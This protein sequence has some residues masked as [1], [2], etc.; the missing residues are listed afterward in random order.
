[1]HINVNLSNEADLKDLQDFLYAKSQE[2]KNF[3]GLL[4][5]AASEVTIVT[6][7]H[8]IK[9][10]KGTKTTGVDKIKM[11]TY[12]QM[13]RE[14]VVSLVQNNLYQY[15]PKP[16]RRVYIAKSN[17]K[18]R[19]LGIPTILDRIIQECIRLI[20][21]PICEAKFYPHSYG[22][23]PYRAQKHAIVDIVHTINLPAKPENKA[24]FA[25][26]GDIKGC[27]DNINHR[28]LLQKLWKIGIHDKRIIAIIKQTLSAGYVEYDKWNQTITGTPQGGIISPLLSRPC[29]KNIGSWLK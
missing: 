3:T 29:L 7:I 10:N 24:V 26:E 25:L 13:P 2:N 8:N 27:F 22:F 21:E 12:L 17:G 6:A 5:A 15:R 19:P 23:R 9:S 16:A 4:E 20:I 1:M 14:D 18:Q 11:D 28:I